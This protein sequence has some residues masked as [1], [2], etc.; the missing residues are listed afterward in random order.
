MLLVLARLVEEA[1]AGATTCRGVSVKAFTEK[2]EEAS[3]FVSSSRS[4][5]ARVTLEQSEGRKYMGPEL[6]LFIMN[7][8]DRKVGRYGTSSQARR[9]CV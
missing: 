1:E 9:L 2:E 7:I 8:C 3:S 5:N 4:H 6:L